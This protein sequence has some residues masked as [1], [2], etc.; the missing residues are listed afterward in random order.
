MGK[1]HNLGEFEYLVL[2]AL[3]RLGNRAYGMTVRRELAETAGREAGIGSVYQTL[4]RLEKKGLITS[5]LAEAD[6][7]RGGKARR[8]YAV[9][10][11]GR[12]ATNTTR[13][14]FARM[15]DG[16]DPTAESR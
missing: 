6:P 4:E 15:W 10:S 14:S 7:V 2:L 12:E 16:L 8:Y 1:G 11:T 3:L 13:D 5:F 9:G